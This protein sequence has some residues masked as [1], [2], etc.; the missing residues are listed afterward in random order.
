MN[1][2]Q[3]SD[4]RLKKIVSMLL[5]IAN[6]CEAGGHK[7]RARMLRALAKESPVLG[8]ENMIARFNKISSQ[9]EAGGHKKRARMFRMLAEEFGRRRYL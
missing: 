8:T 7:N 1:L 6:K 3:I 9:F 5:R 4:K 2:E